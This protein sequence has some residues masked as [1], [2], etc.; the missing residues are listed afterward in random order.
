MAEWKAYQ[1]W[2]VSMG[3]A[4]YMVGRVIDEKRP[5]S[6]AN[7]EWNGF[8]STDADTAIRHAKELN[9]KEGV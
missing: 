4:L 5:L 2:S 3:R 1:V 6:D 8:Y 7:V 9:R